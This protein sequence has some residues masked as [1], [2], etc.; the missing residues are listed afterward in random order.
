[1]NGASMT[2]AVLWTS[3]CELPA[4][5][6]FPFT[7]AVNHTILVAVSVS[8]PT[9]LVTRLVNVKGVGVRTSVIVA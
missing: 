3:I 6:D 1:M 4:G 7:S 8:Q 9:M 5:Y 2:V